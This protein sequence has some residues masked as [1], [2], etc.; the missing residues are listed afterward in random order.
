MDIADELVIA[1]VEANTEKEAIMNHPYFLKPESRKD[2]EEW[3]RGLPEDL[4]GIRQ[5]FYDCDMLMDIVEIE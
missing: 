3:F 5:E 1:I 4:E 2:T